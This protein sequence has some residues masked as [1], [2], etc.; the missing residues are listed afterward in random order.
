M[1]A[2][3]GDSYCFKVFSQFSF[4]CHSDNFEEI[5]VPEIQHKFIIDNYIVKSS[6]KNEGTVKHDRNRYGKIT[7]VKN[8]YL[9]LHQYFRYVR[10]SL[11]NNNSIDIPIIVQIEKH[12]ISE[13]LAN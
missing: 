13:S 10:N 8:H 4:V 5:Q 7:T 3:Y 2:K 6:Q 1:L 11:A 9:E 12:T